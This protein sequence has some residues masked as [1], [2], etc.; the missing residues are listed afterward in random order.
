MIFN[1]PEAM[2]TIFDCVRD[3][4]RNLKQNALARAEILCTTL[5][6][7]TS[8]LGIISLSPARFLGL[9]ETG[10]EAEYIRE[11]VAAREAARSERNWSKADHIRQQLNQ[12]KVEI[13]DQPDGTTRWRRV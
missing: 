2:A 3:I 13:E 9:E 10:E 6:R 1:I 11:L 4:N 5:Q 12:L 7:M 8:V